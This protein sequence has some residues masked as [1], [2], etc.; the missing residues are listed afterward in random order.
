MIFWDENEAK[1]SVKKL[2]AAAP[3]IYPGHDRPFRI[4]SSGSFEY[5]TNKIP[6]NVLEAEK[7]DGSI[8]SIHVNFSEKRNTW[9]HPQAKK[10]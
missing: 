2:V 8:G 6:I 3:V 9:I 7:P 10:S 4:T 1:A 5:I